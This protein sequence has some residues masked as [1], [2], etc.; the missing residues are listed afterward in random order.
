MEDSSQC[1]RCG[2]PV[3]TAAPHE[4]R[5]RGVRGSK[6]CGTLSPE[7]G[8]AH[9]GVWFLS[10][11]LPP[12]LL[13]ST[14]PGTFARRH[15]SQLRSP[16]APFPRPSSASS[17]SLCPWAKLPSAQFRP[18]AWRIRSSPIRSPSCP[19]LPSPTRSDLRL[20][21]VY[22]GAPDRR[23]TTRCTSFPAPFSLLFTSKS[24]GS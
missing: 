16:T 21:P 7:A 5:C 12:P 11:R 18:P 9:G 4:E 22:D 14:S 6:T 2:N 23:C 10:S 24:T 1:H 20:R 8:E 15:G 3:L 13:Y 17:R 19:N